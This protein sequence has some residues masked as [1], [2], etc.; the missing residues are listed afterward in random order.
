MVSQEKEAYLTLANSLIFALVVFPFRNIF[1]KFE[2]EVVFVA[3]VVFIAILWIGR[4]VFGI[5]FKTLDERDI[6]IRYRSGIMAAH[7]F[8]AVI[9]VGATVLWMLHRS[10]MTVPTIQLA[11]LAYF[12]W[13]SMYL[14]LSMTV[15]ILYRRGV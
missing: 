1:P 8:G 10:T 9:M 3:L 5:K 14:T 15:L 6:A 4:K 13:L 7:V 2:C 12:G 11:L